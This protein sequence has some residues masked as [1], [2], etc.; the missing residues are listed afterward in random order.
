MTLHNTQ[1]KSM[2]SLN[3]FLPMEWDTKTPYQ[4][5]LKP[6]TI[7]QIALILLNVS[8]AHIT[9]HQYRGLLTGTPCEHLPP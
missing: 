5:S 8:Q 3:A 9:R 4:N 2:N 7:H 1:L 6:G